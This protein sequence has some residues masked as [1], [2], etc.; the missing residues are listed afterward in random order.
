MPQVSVIIPTYNGEQFIA[1]TLESVFQQTY[2][3]YE[4][5]VIDDGSQ[6]RTRQILQRYCHQI[7][8]VEQ[9]NQGVAAARNRGLALAQGEFIAFLDQDDVM[10]PQKLALQLQCFEQHL[11]QQPALGIVHSGWRL[12][13]AQGNRLADIKPWHDVPQLDA[14]SWIRR[15]PVLFSA[16]L[17]RRQWLEQANG[18]DPQF[19]QACDVDLVQR[20][21]LLGCQSAWVQDITTLYR[22]HDH[23]DS[24]NTL[25]QAEECWAV[26]EQFFAR[27][28]IPAAVRQVEPES[29]YY[30]LVWIAWRLYYT[31]HSD[32]AL[33]YL[34]RSLPYTPFLRTET[35][36]HWV[37]SFVEY[38]AQQQ[39][40]F[41]VEALSCSTAWQELI[42]QVINPA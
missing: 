8:Y 22:Q 10:L 14:A 1:Q 35:I 25:V 15:M 41:D 33:Q 42:H 7:R 28:D 31:E 30:T 19:R 27:A 38:S 21:V 23:N 13:D 37:N 6:D 39:Y 24:L 32:L 2:R 12:I 17:F 40:S 5:I 4:V 34:K 16:M 11:Q 18:L 26:R 3:D 9:Q 36:L 29:R 20:L